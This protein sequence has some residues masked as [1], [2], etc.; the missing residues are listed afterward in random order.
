MTRA[1]PGLVGQPTGP[2]QRRRTLPYEPSLDGLRAFAIVVVVLYHAC[3]AAGYRDWFRGGFLGVSVFF[4]LSGF[5][6]T[7]LLLAEH[8]RSGRIAFDR[9]W[10]RRIRRLVPALLTV[11]AGVV[12]LSAF[13]VLAA[14]RTDAAAAIWS[15]TNWHVIIGG[16]QK[17]LQTI[18]GPLGP[19]WS[20]AVEEQLYLLLVLAVLVAHRRSV[21]QRALLAIALGAI[22][23]SIASAN[24]VSDWQPR[25]EY[26]T[27]TRAAE[28]AVGV[29][30]AVVWR[31]RPHLRWSP[32]VGDLVA[33]L[34]LAALVGLVAFADFDPP[35]LLRGGF[36]IVALV[37][38]LTITGLLAH[39]R[40]ER[41]LGTRPV[42]YLG[43]LSY[44]LYLVHWPVI[45]T[46]NGPR[47]GIAGWRL[48]G[49]QVAAGVAC[50]ALLHHV[51]EQPIR[52]G[53]STI[54]PTMVAYLGAGLALTAVAVV[55]LD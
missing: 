44:S 16:E 8:D 25:L 47:L 22:A 33:A 6:I 23:V 36:T 26:G 7:S 9:F 32:K 46:L 31:S 39:G 48:V 11:V 21:P 41:L 15:F 52:R 18:V 2:D 17:L 29:V 1:E 51:V 37:S 30:L 35:W 13:D 50:A 40:V 43:T 27:D 54:G 5:L 4:T 49:I 10:V 34:G 20:L 24:L 28:V 45:L 12:V 55:V 19:T 53:R 42:V 14:R 38:A 3:S